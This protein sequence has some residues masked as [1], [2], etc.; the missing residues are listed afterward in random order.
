MSSLINIYICIFSSIESVR[1]VGEISAK[2]IFNGVT[3]YSDS[4]LELMTEIVKKCRIKYEP[5]LFEN[6]NQTK[7]RTYI[8][9]IA[10]SEE[11]HPDSFVDTTCMF[12]N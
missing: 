12:I 7:A 8:Q 3:P 2:C 4:S 11:Y 10:L 1:N 6:P 5:A 9:A